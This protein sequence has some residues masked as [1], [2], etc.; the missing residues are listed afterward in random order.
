MTDAT[1]PK[2][3]AKAKPKVKPATVEVSGVPRE[4]PEPGSAARKACV[5]R[6]EI[7]E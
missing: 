7:K 5:L 6:G 3:K 2:P 1:E 4:L